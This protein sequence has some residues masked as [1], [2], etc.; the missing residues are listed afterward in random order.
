VILVHGSIFNGP[1]TWA[2]QRPLASRWQLEVLN[3]RGYG[4][5]LPP[6]TRSDFEEDAIDI[7]AHLGDGAH[8]VGISYGALASFFAAMIRP[9]AI[10]S[11]TL[12]EPGAF[13]T[14]LPHPAAARAIEDRKAVVKDK[15]LREFV[16]SFARAV[17]GPDAPPPVPFPDPFPPDLEQG[18]RTTMTQREPHSIKLPTEK[19]KD[20]LYPKLVVSGGHHPAYEVVCDVLQQ[21][22]NAERQTIK[23]AGHLVPRIGAAFNE[24]LNAFLE[25][26]NQRHQ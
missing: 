26:A 3:R 12:I 14:A 2:E 24:C 19:L 1:R 16:I 10:H 23:G 25:R 5:S 17:R 7:A 9:Q 8:L 18:I 21:L 11:L 6:G 13:G 20:T 15:G 22:L 4:G